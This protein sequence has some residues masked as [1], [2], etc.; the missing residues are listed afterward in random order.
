MKPLVSIIAVNY[1][2]QKV[3]R[4]MIDSIRNNSYSNIEIIVVDNAS[5]VSPKAYLN[6]NY[7]EVK[8]IESSKN[9]GFAGGN[10]LGIKES[11]G[12]F[13]FF[14]NNDAE[15]TNGVI[16][17]MLELFEQ[18]PKLGIVSPKIC[19]YKTGSDKKSD[20]YSPDI[21]QYVGSTE[22]HNLTA[23]NRTIGY[24]ESDLGQYQTAKPTAYAHGAAMMVSRS[25]IEKVGMMPEAFFLYYEE[26]DWC[27]Q[28]RR[29]GFEI[30]IQPKAKVYHK[31]SWSVKK[32]SGL[33]TFY[34]N[35]NRIL[36]M[37]R[38]RH[39]W[40]MIGF[41]L[42]FLF[43]TVPKNTIVFLLKGDFLNIQAFYK[44]IFWNIKDRLHQNRNNLK[45]RKQPNNP[46]KSLKLQLDKIDI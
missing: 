37:R 19:F 31:E 11:N 46:S 12:D 15:L 35:R 9:L 40:Q 4:E 33:K 1:N 38:N 10:N 39:I 20:P 21:L 36:F 24:L 6:E 25:V 16:E 34:I 7:K 22:V 42:F 2:G 28:I 26:L 29:V 5:E 17:S 18:V 32:T 41:C 8:V 14:L 43:L 3:T 13:L 44:S 45:P 27:E 23:R 30:Y